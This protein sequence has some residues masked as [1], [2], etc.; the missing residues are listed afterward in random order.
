MFCSFSH[1]FFFFLYPSMSAVH[2][3]GLSFCLYLSCVCMYMPYAYKYTQYICN[4]KVC[5]PI[6]LAWRLWSRADSF[7]L[8][9]GPGRCRAFAFACVKLRARRAALSQ[10]EVTMIPDPSRHWDF[11]R[12]CSGILCTFIYISWN[13]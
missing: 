4:C 10:W 3:H 12:Q 13:H 8:C 6:C 5:V 7:P 1:V 11:G 2:L 9:K